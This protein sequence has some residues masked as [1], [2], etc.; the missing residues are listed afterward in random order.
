MTTCNILHETESKEIGIL[1]IH[2][3]IPQLYGRQRNEKIQKQ[4]KQSRE[5]CDR[6]SSA[7]LICS[8]I[9]P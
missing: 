8:H 3:D 1:V 2:M 5:K 9:S 6:E 7:I 4:T